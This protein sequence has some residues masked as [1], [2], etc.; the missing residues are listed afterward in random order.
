MLGVVGGRPGLS[1]QAVKRTAKAGVI[2][3]RTLHARA[4]EQLQVDLLKPLVDAPDRLAPRQDVEDHR[5]HTLRVGDLRERMLRQI[6]V[7]DLLKA[8]PVD[9]AADD[10]KVADGEN[11]VLK[12]VE[13]HRA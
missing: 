2:E 13:V 12:G 5:H 10:G 3:E 9:Q 1:V 4:H 11:T 8:E 6:A 7:D